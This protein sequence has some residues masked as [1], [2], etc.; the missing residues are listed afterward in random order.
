MCTKLTPAGLLRENL[1]EEKTLGEDF[2]LLMRLCGRIAGVVNLPSTGYRVV[3][4]AG[5]ATRRGSAA[6]FSKAYVDI[7]RQA[8]KVEEEIVPEHPEL[9]DAA[10]AFAMIERLYYLLHV[11]VRDMNRQNLFYTEVCGYLRRNLRVMCASPLIGAKKKL[12]LLLL[13]AAPVTVRKV[14]LLLRGRKMAKEKM[15]R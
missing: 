15:T 13:T 6:Q 2:G 14:H 7:V 4:R 10:K 1:F 3:H 9:S 5:S 8:D 11:P 12:Y